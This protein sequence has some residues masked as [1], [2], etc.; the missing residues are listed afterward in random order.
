MSSGAVK[1]KNW[2]FDKGEK[3]KLIWIGEPFKHNN[4][5]M[6]Y[7]Y[8]KGNN[9]TKKIALDWATIHLLS[10]DKYYTDGNLNHGETIA[11]TEV[12]DINLS[13]VKAE[14]REKDWEI[15]IGRAKEKTKSKTFNFVAKGILYTIP[16]IEVIRAVI[17]PDKFL[18]NRVVEMDTLENYFTY[19]LTANKLDIHFTSEYESKLLSNEKINHL[20][21]IITNDNIFKM[22]NAIGQN[23]WEKRELKFEFLFDRFN[24]K[25]R[26]EK[27]EKYVRILQILSLK[28][29]RINIEEVNIFHP[30]LEES[31]L[32]NE[33]K[34][35]RQFVS[36]G[37]E[38]RELDTNADGAT[39]ESEMLDTF[40]IS[41]E[42]ER[43]PTIHKK[44]NGRRIKRQKEDE[45]TKTHIREDDNLRS[46]ADTGGED[47]I[48]G[49]EFTNLS[50]VEEKGELQEFIEVLR[51]LEKREL[52]R[53][54]DIIIDSLPGGNKG[55]KFSKLSDGIRMRRYAIGKVNMI[56][57]RQIYM[58]DIERENR[59]LSMLLLKWNVYFEF[60]KNFSKLL[61]S[62]VN[63]NGKWCNNDIQKLSNKGIIVQRIKHC[64]KTKYEKE[65]FLYE[66]LLKVSQ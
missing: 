61:H 22:F 15:W 54:V 9:L 62:L 45:N 66:K 10:V 24:I 42:Y 23:L 59:A 4:K 16:I 56:Y 41:H 38:D 20:S 64:K 39:K 36:K 60:K 7:A 30:S 13:G 17:A 52:I 47:L 5:W 43:I 27:K 18:L 53:S 44:R 48:K 32:S 29:K 14:Y 34:K 37:N 6:V 31:E 57:D 3:V 58:V 51:L 21:W 12:I 11:N 33:T 63:D 35:I 40:M 8:F 28:R 55:K 1:I 65:K 26:V 25:A 19:D 50:K 2:P 49:L 46:T